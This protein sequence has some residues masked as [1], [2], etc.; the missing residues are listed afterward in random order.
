MAGDGTARTASA[1]PDVQSLRVRAL[2]L[3]DVP[4]VQRLRK[5]AGWNQSDAD[6]GR[7]LAWEPDGCWVGELNGRVVASTTVTTYGTRIAWIGMVLVDEAW[8]RR[9]IGRRM[10]GHAEAYLAARGVESVALDATPAGA[11][12]YASLGYHALHGLERWRGIVADIPHPGPEAPSVVEA[13]SRA[14]GPAGRTSEDPASSG[15]AAGRTAPADVRPMTSADL[16]AVAAYDSRAFG[17]DRSHILRALFEGQPAGCVVA[18]RDGSVRDYALGRPGARAWHLGPLVADDGNIAECL[19]LAALLRHRG[20]EALMDVVT[21]NG[22]AVA[23]A[24][25]VGL[26]PVRPFIRMTRGAPPPAP[27]LRRLYTSAGPEIG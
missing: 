26:A 10:L 13:M 21:S 11:P 22:A 12:L 25:R 3:A 19:A 17:M 1:G 23:L 18:E 24:G 20:E 16:A 9:G 4:V 2:T 7:L 5:Q 6:W 15:P 14:P 8:R 27:D